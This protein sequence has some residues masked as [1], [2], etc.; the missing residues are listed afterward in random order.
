MFSI[1]KDTKLYGSFAA[2]AGSK[3]CKFHNAGFQH[4]K[5]NAIYKSFSVNSILSAL[6]AM[7]IL[8]ISG[9]AISMPFKQEALRH[10]DQVTKSA[11]EIGSINTVI[12]D[13]GKLTG[14]NTDWLAA[15]EYASG[16]SRQTPIYI[17][18]NGGYAA[19]VKYALS[20]LE[21]NINVITRKNW[22][23][24]LDLR[25]CIVW[26]CT[27]VEKINM[28]QSC[29]FIDCIVGTESGSKLAIL[30][31]KH[32]FELYTGIDYPKELCH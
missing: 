13:N 24:I 1:D 4:L 8:N 18:G 28:N 15:S 5:I 2:K 16:W 30:Q 7:R 21:F 31:A 19:A 26:N 3:G 23:D 20:L 22:D 27:P 32:Q 12:N 9:A 6:T 14:H 25:N 17:L 10:V 29:H 11:S